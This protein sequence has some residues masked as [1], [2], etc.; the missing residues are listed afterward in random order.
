[1]VR[2]AVKILRREH[3]TSRA[4]GARFQREA[5]AAAAVHHPN[6]RAVS[7]L[8]LLPN[9]TRLFAMELLVGLDLADTLSFSGGALA[10]RR[11]DRVGARR[12]SFGRPR[13]RHRSPRREARERLS[14]SC[15]GRQR[16]RKTPGFRLR[17]REGRSGA[18]GSARD[19]RALH[20]GRYPRVHGPRTS[21]G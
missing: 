19:H 15:A 3:Q 10:P 12:W 9:G 16:D 18:P 8:E 4:L 2:V 14:G 13:P 1:G 21:A 7:E 20:G 17:S 11:A 5:T 6:V